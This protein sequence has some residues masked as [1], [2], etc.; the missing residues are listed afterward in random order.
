MS[1]IKISGKLSN[2]IDENFGVNQGGVL[3]P[4]LFV[5]FLKDLGKF[6]KDTGIVLNDEEI[7]NYL[8][9]EDDLVLLS[10]TPEGLQSLLDS[11]YDFTKQWH[12]IVTT[13]KTK[14]MIIS[15]AKRTQSITFTINAIIIEQVHEYKYLGCII[16]DRR[17]ITEKCCC[18][19]CK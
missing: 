1:Q 11:L 5:E 9:W 3:S 6:F 12:L 8:L 10:S 4:F 13:L 19:V 15:G 7:F 17:N 16:A 18:T 14:V 2:Y